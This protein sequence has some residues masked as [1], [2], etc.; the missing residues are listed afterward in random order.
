MNE[1]TTSRARVP[2]P[3]IWREWGRFLRRPALPDRRDPFGWRAIGDVAW[4]LSLDIAFA[5][6]LASF[7]TTLAQRMA[8]KT[9]EF[10]MLTERG[11]VFTLL[12]GA[13]MMPIFEELVSR[14]WI[15]GRRRHLALAGVGIAALA[16][17]IAGRFAGLG[18]SATVVLLLGWVGIAIYVGIRAGNEVPTWFA[19]GFPWL[20][21]GSAL[22][23]GLAHMTNYELKQPLML[24]P[25]VV[26]QFM[27][28]LIFGFARV[29]FGMWA[30]IALHGTSNALFL[31]LALTGG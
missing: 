24:V 10:A 25:F 22:L 31:T 15:D 7:L 1:A 30:N 4:L 11:V 2:V 6:P 29:R 28:A 9:P 20:F 5:L 27:A 12:V 16:S 3:R 18:T 14:G 17:L 23:F 19:R 13:L 21:Y 26:P 8:I